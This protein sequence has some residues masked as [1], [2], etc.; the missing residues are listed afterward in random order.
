LGINLVKTTKTKHDFVKIGGAANST[1][2][3][4][5]HVNP[6]IIDSHDTDFQTVTGRLSIKLD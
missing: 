3:T 5:S 6:F 1:I 4:G 2:T